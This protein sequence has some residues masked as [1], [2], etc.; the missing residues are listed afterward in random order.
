MPCLATIVDV[1][2]HTLAEDFLRYALGAG[3]VHL[4]VNLALSRWAARRQV[5]EAARPGW[6]QIR[7]EIATSLRTVLIFALVGTALGLAVRTGFTRVYLD[8]AERGTA[9]LLLSALLL[10]VAHDA[11]FYWAHRIMHH[12]RLYRRLHRTHHRSHNPT[13]FTAYSF[14]TGEALV[15]ATF[16]PAILMLLPAHPAAIGVFLLHMILRNAIGHCGVEVFPAGRDGRPLFGWLTT[17]THHDLHHENA[18][19]NM[20]LYFTVWDRLMGTE[21]PDYHA[22]F[23]AARRP[24]PQRGAAAVLAAVAALALATPGEAGGPGAYWATR[25]MGLV[26]HVAPCAGA[27]ERL[28][29]WVTRR[30]DAGGTFSNLGVAGKAL[31]VER[32]DGG[33]CRTLRLWPVSRLDGI[34]TL[35][36]H[37]P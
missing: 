36:A 11:W 32:C 22:R 25:D 27:P 3:G 16:L 13:A 29:G 4:V 14:D 2:S 26:L 20:G 30:R 6:A 1:F 10:M 8:P 17:V 5:R 18:L 9:Y 34:V 31:Q 7:R 24:G 33:A 28:C 12:P 35:G 19:W 23:R 15:H 21:H 37:F